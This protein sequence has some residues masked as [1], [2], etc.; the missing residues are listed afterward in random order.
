MLVTLDQLDNLVNEIH[1]NLMLA[2]MMPFEIIANRFPRVVRDLSLRA[3]KEIDF[4]IIG[5]EIE[6]D[7]VILD[8]IGDPLIHILRNSIDHGIEPPGVRINQGKSR[9]GK[10]NLIATREKES[11]FIE[12]ED[13][14]A[15]IDPQ[16]I[17]VKAIE[18]GL[19][20]RE[21]AE[22]LSSDELLMFIWLPGFSTSNTVTDISGRGV[23]MDVVKTQIESI[24]GSLDIS[25]EPH[26]GTRISLKLPLTVAIVDV[27][28]TKMNKSIF[29]IPISKINRTMEIARKNIIVSRG[30]NLLETP[31]GII[32]LISLNQVLNIKS[33]NGKKDILTIILVEIKKKQIGI[34]VDELL[35]Q[36][37][38]VI[39]P[40][41]NPLERIKGFSGV[42]IL[43]DG[44]LVLILDLQNLI[45]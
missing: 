23:G 7:R 41:G 25:S 40:L 42:S 45:R 28:L 17:K 8:E 1:T 2:R 27:L 35:G 16:N 19:I 26:R 32:P 43:G 30:Q 14:G 13:D 38:M 6:L 44:Q 18:K 29:A 39:K 31:E 3:G 11:V 33:L 22:L 10:I 5:S 9:R 34:I 24:G 15:G 20:S 12:V 37:E 36:E 21:Q 4:Q